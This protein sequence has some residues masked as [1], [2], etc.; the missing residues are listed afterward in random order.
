MLP[1]VLNV[2]MPLKDQGFIHWFSEH[3]KS[4]IFIFILFKDLNWTGRSKPQRSGQNI[5]VLR[6]V[7]FGRGWVEKEK[8]SS[9]YWAKAVFG[10]TFQAEITAN[11]R[12]EKGETPRF[13]LT[14][15][16]WTASNKVS[17]QS[18]FFLFFI[19]FFFFF[20]GR[21]PGLRGVE[22]QLQRG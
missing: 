22:P 11:R 4:R 19:P 1:V 12:E 13:L 10:E 21:I 3:S 6:S 2:T 18:F 5:F 8:N 15:W 9:V 7:F 16:N 14:D 20:W 17:H